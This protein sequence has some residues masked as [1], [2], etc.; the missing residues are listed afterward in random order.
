MIK[1]IFEN[2]DIIVV[3]KPAGISVHAGVGTS[4]KTLVD[5]LLVKFPEIK[6]VG[7]ALPR[8]FRKA[9][10]AREPEIRP[11][12]VH[13]LDKDT[14]GV[15]VVA[16][17]QK[18]FEYLKNLFKNR[19]VEKKYLALVHG[20]L[21]AK[22]G[23]VEGEMGRSKKDF[24]KQALVRG[25]ISVRKERYSLTHFK[26][27]CEFEKNTLLEVSPKTGRMHQIRVHLHSIGHPIVGDK[28]YT[29]KEYKNIPTPRMFLHAAS[30]RFIGPDDKKYFF[31]S[32]PP[33][34]FKK[35]L[36]YKSAR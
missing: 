12:I 16:R 6:D 8:T 36:D 14:S 7:D 21:K 2:K 9:D 1:I 4:E 29:F 23:Q 20:K 32:E 22:V 33:E 18:T 3:D 34:E 10:G 26:V 11:G 30:I 28:K 15:M 27:K 35:Y 25:K 13:R 24:R 5:F 17:N 19:R 31:E